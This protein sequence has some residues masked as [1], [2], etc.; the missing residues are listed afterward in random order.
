MELFQRSIIERKEERWRKA[1]IV[2]SGLEMEKL[3]TNL[4]GKIN[5][6]FFLKKW[7][8]QGGH[9]VGSTEIEARFLLI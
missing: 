6:I 9:V 8:K 1:C 7:L 3:T 5:D 2:S 4:Y